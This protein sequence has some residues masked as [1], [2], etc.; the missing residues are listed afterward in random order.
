MQKYEYLV[1]KIGVDAAEN[2]PRKELCVL[3]QPPLRRRPRE[4]DVPS[5]RRGALRRLRRQAKAADARAAA[6]RLRSG[7]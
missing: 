1:A 3:A 7:M 2:E 5:L 6:R 4:R